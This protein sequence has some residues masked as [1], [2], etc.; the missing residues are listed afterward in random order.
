M[1]PLYANALGSTGYGIVGMI[2]VT[3]AA[4]NIMS[5]YGVSGAVNRFYFTRESVNDKNQLIAT[6]LVVMLLMSIVSC[7]P[8]MVFSEFLGRLVFGT[9]GAGKYILIGILA[10]MIDSNG[11]VG[12]QYLIIRQRAIAVAVLSVIRLIIALSLN[13]YFIVILKIGVMGV[14]L[15]QLITAVIFLFIFQGYTLK[16][17]GFHFNK[18]DA[19]DLVSY[20]LPLIPGFA[21]NFVRNNTDKIILRTFLG[22]SQIG[23]YSMVMNFALLINIIIFSPF[24]KTW[25]PKRM[26]LSL[27]EDG[28]KLISKVVTLH[29]T[30]MFFLGV[31][32]ASEIPLLIRLLA[33]PEFWIN[34]VVAI[35]AVYSRIIYCS[36]YH[37]VFGLVYGKKTGK[38]SYIA[39]MI[40][41]VSI[42]TYIFFIRKFGLLGAFIAGSLIHTLQAFLGYYLAKPFFNISYNIKKII[43]MF[44]SAIILSVLISQVSIEN[45][46]WPIKLQA[47]LSP[48]IEDFLEITYLNEI[49]NGKILAM[50]NDKFPLILEGALKAV[51]SISYLFVMVIFGIVDK[52]QLI[53]IKEMVTSLI[54]FKTSGKIA[55]NN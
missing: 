39:I 7:V 12:Q 51:L 15:S 40:A 24:M 31:F 8:P 22:I 20:F 6:S 49:K 10:F 3:T 25:K 33:P 16:S 23:V 53:R 47:K 52:K 26:E 19:K 54:F 48:L 35:F 1:L 41:V 21:A 37:W 11:F 42:P 38:I 2:G 55:T 9:E 43:V 4:L 36:Y 32:L 27:D 13:I 14:L 50:F 46:N 30:S 28:S 44:I 34:P 45:F 29:I 5:R 17:T 18:K